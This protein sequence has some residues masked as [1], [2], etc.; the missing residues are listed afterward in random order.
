MNDRWNRGSARQASAP[1][2]GL[3]ALGALGATLG[4]PPRPDHPQ[5]WAHAIVALVVNLVI[6]A[7]CAYA[8][9]DLWHYFHSTTPCI[10]MGTCAIPRGR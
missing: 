4:R 8:L 7:V 1:L 10:R 5:F 2:Y 6:V 3:A 9:I